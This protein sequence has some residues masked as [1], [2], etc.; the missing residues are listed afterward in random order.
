[1]YNE[2]GVYSDNRIM[3]KYMY[4]GICACILTAV[5]VFIFF[6]TWYEFAS[7]HNNTGYL[8]GKGNLGM[9]V[10]IYTS[11]FTLAFYGLGGYKIGVNRRTGIISSQIVAT[12]TVD[13]I[14]VFVSMAITGQ[15]RFVFLLLGE[16]SVMAILQIAACF[17]LTLPMSWLYQSLFPPLQVLEIYGDHSNNLYEKINGRADKY[18][19][20]RSIKYSN[21]DDESLRQEIDSFDAVLINDIPS[22]IKNSI[23]KICFELDKRVYFTPKLS[24]IIVRSS[25]NINLFDTP[26]YLCRNIGMPWYKRV[27]KRTFDIVLSLIA[28]IV[29]LPIMLITAVAI[30]CEDGGPVFFKQERVTMN[31]RRFNIL[32]FRSMIVDAEK[33]GKPQPAGVNDD[34]ITKVGSFIRRTRIDELPQI[35]NILKGEMSIVGPRPERWE[36][37][38]KYCQEIP[39]F[40]FRLKVKGGLT[41]YA[42]VYGKYNTSAL[43]KLKLDMMYI[44]NWSLLLDIQIIFETI[45]VLF[46]RESTEGFKEENKTTLKA[47]ENKY[48]NSLL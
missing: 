3:T 7:E 43:D 33:D 19:V 14:Q 40:L 9:S 32:K 13:I 41:G 36:H 2:D 1:M 31:A 17:A 37:N 44:M 39:E 15:F 16:Y 42:Q 27:I 24:D 8:L 26:L 21:H 45:K 22:Q 12:I 10:I 29:T 46:K 34:R 23:L 5:N 48:N 6:L 18:H 28:F 38:E 47:Y 11:L 35:I 20:A 30:K 25:D 4:R